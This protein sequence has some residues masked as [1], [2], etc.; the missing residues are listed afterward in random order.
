MKTTGLHQLGQM[1]FDRLPVKGD[2]ERAIGKPTKN[3]SSII[4]GSS[5]NGKTTGIIR[6]IKMIVGFDLRAVYFSLEEG[7]GGTM[8]DAFMRADMIKSHSGKI[9]LAEDATL[10]EIITYSTKRGSPEVVVIDSLDYLN[11]TK[12]GYQLLRKKL[13]NKIIIL[14]SWSEG[15]RPKTSAGK[16]IEYMVDIKLFIKQFVIFPKS[17][18]GGNHPYVVWE[19]RARMLNPKLFLDLDKTKKNLFSHAKDAEIVDEREGVDAHD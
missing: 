7:I 19:E 9:I 11:L 5:G 18:F 8:Q 4:Y 12:E 13:K 15:S 3:F 6:F 1:K 17:R 16:D 2:W 10:E 14:I